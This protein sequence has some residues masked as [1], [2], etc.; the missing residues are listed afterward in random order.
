MFCDFPERTTPAEGKE[1]TDYDRRNVLCSSEVRTLR[2][3]VI[4]EPT[5]DG[6]QVMIEAESVNSVSQHP[7]SKV[8]ILQVR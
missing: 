4:H 5:Y 8:N 6:R 7:L 1:E 2:L 3:Y